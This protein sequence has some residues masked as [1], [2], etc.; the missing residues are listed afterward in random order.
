MFSLNTLFCLS[1]HLMESKVQR[2]NDRGKMI[3]NYFIAHNDEF[4]CR[5]CN[6]VVHSKKSQI[7]HLEAHLQQSHDEVMKSI[8]LTSVMAH[9]KLLS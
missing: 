4:E 5:I 2:R 1:F 3:E 8:N 7:H 9:Q 6:S